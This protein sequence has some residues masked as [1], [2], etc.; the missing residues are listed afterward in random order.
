[1]TGRIYRRCLGLLALTALWAAGEGRLE[2]GKLWVGP[3]LSNYGYM[4]TFEYPGGARDYYILEQ[5]SFFSCVVA[6]DTVVLYGGTLG[7][8]LDYGWQNADGRFENWVAAGD[9]INQV[10]L[11]ATSDFSRY[12]DGNLSLEVSSAI[13][14][15]NHPHYDDFAV[16][17]HTFTNLG[18]ETLTDFVYGSHLPVDVG[19]SGISYK[20]LDDYGEHHPG[21]GLTYMYDDDGDGG[22]TP[23]LAGQVLVGIDRGSGLDTS[24][25]WTTAHFYQM[26]NPITGKRD[27]LEKMGSG[28]TLTSA[29]PG[30]WSI[31]N[32]VGSFT[33]DPGAS[34]TF[35][36]A[37][38]YGEGLEGILATV[39]KVAGLAANGFQ[40]PAEEQP[41][42]APEIATVQVSSRVIEL[43]WSDRPA[44]SADFLTYRIYRSVVATIGP[45]E[46]L[47]DTP[48]SAFVDVGRSG[49][50]VYYSITSVGTTGNE[51]GKWGRS[52]RT[53]EAVRPLGKAVTE[54]DQ[55]LVVPNP[56]LGGADWESFDYENR[57]YFTQLPEECTVYV[58]TLMGD[59]VAQLSHNLA[60][61]LTPDGSGD[62]AWDL[63]S[64][65]RQTIAS[66]LYLFRVVTP[67]G[68]ESTGKF[69]V[70]KGER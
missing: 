35:T 36:M 29:S 14:A 54:L 37:V 52:N 13:R 62:E 43:S 5:S 33:L 40:I 34:I 30:P 25:G 41:P 8:E 9:G 3:T 16:L 24:A 39:G 38:V 67:Q 65:N 22:L 2:V 44:L 56:Y 70:V 45:W 32:A 49:F 20:D 12:P 18:L 63:L 15:F 23:Y 48:S 27:L 55:V 1:M 50:P 64:L 10:Y 69:V 19:A 28:I 51:S 4:G 53:L 42:P 7:N 6:G 31:I 46:H 61:D 66:G 60:K 68:N 59:L 17:E 21:S 26:V 47:A 57:I 58:Y 11:T